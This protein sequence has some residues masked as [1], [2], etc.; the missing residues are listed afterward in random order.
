MRRRLFLGA[1][2]AVAAVPARAADLDVAIVGAGVAGLA[3]ARALMAAGRA[4]QVIEARDRLGGRVL[5]DGGLGFPFDGGAMWLEPGPL[6]R[7]LGGK[8]VPIGGEAIVIDGKEISQADYERYAKTTAEAEKRVTVLHMLRPADKLEKL[9]LARLAARPP[10][11]RRQT[12]AEGLGALVARWGARVP[13]KLGTRLVRL[14]STGERVVLV[15]TAGEIAA[16]ACIVTIPLAVLAAGGVGFAPPL[17]AQRRAALQALPPTLMTNVA[18]A[19]SRRVIDMPADFRIAALDRSERAV[20]LLVRPQGR[21]AAIVTVTGERSRA[22]DAEGPSAAG[23]F[24]LATVAELF[25][26][27]VRA[28]MAGNRTVRWTADP[29]ARGAWTEPTSAVLAPH[30]DRVFFAGDGALSAAHAS[31]LAAAKAALAMLAPQRR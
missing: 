13:V 29:L 22:L 5:T 7:E 3:A 21:E 10:F 31:G 24:A 1:A 12:F 18:V 26:T 17:A 30:H 27:Q 23:A 20:E 16:R 28:A 6:A 11:E 25:G 9:A 15:T 4:V 8:A 2:G 19:F 14:D